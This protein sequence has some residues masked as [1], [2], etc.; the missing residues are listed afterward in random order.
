M[1]TEIVMPNMGFD[2]QEARL[3]E[4]LKQPG[5]AVKK[6]DLIAV[7]ESDKA[8]V[9][10]ESVAS[11]ILLEQLV[12]AGSDVPVGN[13][14]ARIGTP[15]ERAKPAPAVPAAVVEEKMCVFEN[16]DQQLERSQTLAIKFFRIQLKLDLDFGQSIK[17]SQLRPLHCESQKIAVSPT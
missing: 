17:Q 6:G 5:D 15:D 9:E 7:I 4:W 14:I 3:I 16:G 10:L 12:P 11:G 1:A 2:T 13:V 8:N